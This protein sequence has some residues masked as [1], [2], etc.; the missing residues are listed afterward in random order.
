MNPLQALLMVDDLVR[1]AAE[2]RPVSHETLTIALVLA[3][4]FEPDARGLATRLLAEVA[5]AKV[6]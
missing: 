1:R 2:G 3:G 4:Y 5:R 6:G